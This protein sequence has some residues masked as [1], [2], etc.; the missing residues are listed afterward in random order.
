VPFRS[1]LIALVNA[2]SRVGYVAIGRLLLCVSMTS[3]ALD[4]YLSGDM[5]YL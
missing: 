2:N 5:S 4:G 3:H 1:S